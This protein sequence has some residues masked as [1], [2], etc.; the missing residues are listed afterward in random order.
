[1]SRLSHQAAHS[2]GKRCAPKWLLVKP[3]GE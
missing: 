1:V 3:L 2:F